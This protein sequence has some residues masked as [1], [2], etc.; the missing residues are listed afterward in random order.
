[1][2]PSVKLI[3]MT[4]SEVFVEG[5]RLTPEQLIEYTARVSN[6]AGQEKLNTSFKL[7]KYLIE[8]N[9]ISPLEMVDF[10]VEIETSRAIAAQILRHWSFSFQEFSQRYAQASEYVEYEARRQDTKNRQNSIDDMSDE[11]KLWF[12]EAQLKVWTTS[13]DLYDQALEKGIA[14]EQARFLLPLNTKTRLYMKA[15]IRDWYFYLKLRSGNGTQMEHMDIAQTI[16]DQI[17]KVYFP[18]I[19]SVAG[20]IE[21]Q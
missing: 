19:A 17:F 15:N 5:K 7:L 3:S 12:T 11:D 9:H 20:W 16:I 10:T 6:P 21:S 4:Q 1:M 14:K 13:K 18:V 2:K 8:N